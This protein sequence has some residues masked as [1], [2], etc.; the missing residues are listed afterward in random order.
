MPSIILLRFFLVFFAG[1]FEQNVIS[2]L[3]VFYTERY[4]IYLQALFSLLVLVQVAHHKLGDYAFSADKKDV[5]RLAIIFK[6]YS[7]LV[8][9]SVFIYFSFTY[10]LFYSM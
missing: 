2:I 3:N 6:C 8:H 7:V 1:Y 9:V 4:S 10:C 5:D